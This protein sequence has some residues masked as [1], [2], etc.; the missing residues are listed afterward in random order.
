MESLRE[1]A[2]NHEDLFISPT[3]EEAKLVAE[4]YTVRHFQQ[5]IEQQKILKG[6]RIADPFIV[7]RAAVENCAIVTLEQL[8]PNGAKIPNICEHFKLPCL[9]LEQF[10]EEEEWEF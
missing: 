10:M 2:A 7:A 8:R 1:W 3:A 5:N 9:S 4:I 6:G